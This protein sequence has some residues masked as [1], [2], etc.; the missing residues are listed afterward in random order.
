MTCKHGPHTIHRH[1]HMSYVQ[2]IVANEAGLKS[3]LEKIGLIAGRKIIPLMSC[4]QCFVLAR[5]PAWTL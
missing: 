1:D 3:C 5:M 2:N 4:S